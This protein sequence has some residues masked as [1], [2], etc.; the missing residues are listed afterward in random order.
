MNKHLLYLT[1]GLFLACNVE[2]PEPLLFEKVPEKISGMNFRNDVINSEEF[3][4]F[5][6]RNFYNGGGVAIGDIN[7]DGLSDIFFTSNMGGNKLYLNKGSWKFED[8][9]DQAGIALDSKWSTG[10]VMVDINGDEMLD[11]YVCNAG[12]RKGSNQKNALFINNG[13]LTF[14]EEA[15]KYGLDD[16]GYTTHAAFFDFDRDGD[17]D[18][19]LLNNSFIPVNTL[20]YSNKRDRRAK[21]WPVKDF[22]KGGGDKLL[23]NN[24]G[25]YVD[26]SEEVGI[27]GSLIGFGLGVTVGDVNNDT[28]PDIYVSND[29]FERDYLYINNQD[30]TF[31]EELEQRINHLSLSS[32]GADMADIDNDGYTEIFVTDMLPDDEYR[33]KTTT[34]FDNIDLHLLKVKQGFY[35]QFMH[36]TLQRNNG[37]GSFSEISNYS[38][39]AASDWSWGALMFDMNNDSYT[40]ILVCNGIYQDVIDQDFIDFFANEITQKMA[41]SGKKAALDSVVSKMPS[42]PIPNKAFKN[43]G[44]LKFEDMSDQWGFGQETFSNGAAYGDLDNDGDL[45]LVINNVN[46]TALVYRNNTTN[47]FIG[48]KLK[49]KNLNPFA[50]GAKV[51]I[52]Q[53]ENILNKELIPSRG[54]QSSV[55]YKLV[56]G[57]GENTQIDSIHILWPDG[58]LTRF[59]DFQLNQYQLV[60]FDAND[61]IQ[62]QEPKDDGAPLFTAVAHNF[63]SHVEDDYNDFYYERNIPVQ[64]SKESPVAAIGDINMDGIDDIYIGAAAGQ[65]SQLYLSTNNGFKKSQEAF[66]GQFKSFEDTCA[67][68]FDADNDGDL[69]LV[70][71]S[72]GNNAT[73]INRAFRDRLYIN[74]NGQFELVFGA[75]PAKSYNTATINPYDFDDDGDLDLF[76][77]SRSVPGDYG[78]SPGSFIYINNGK[79]QFQD[80]TPIVAPELALA[81][82][83]TDAIWA[84][85]LPREGVELI[86]TG[87]WMS[88]KIL[89]YDGR[90]FD[91][92]DTELLKYSGWWQSIE[93]SDLD[94]DGDQDLILGNLGENFYLEA[95]T[96]HPLLIW[97]NDFNGNGF[98]EKIITRR[99]DGKDMPV[100]MKR[101]L[102]DQL[103][104]LKKQNLM[105]SSYATKSIQELINPNILKSSTI[106]QINFLSSAI[107][108]NDGDGNFEMMALPGEVQLSCINDILTKDLNQDGYTDLIFAGNNHSFLPQF[109]RLDACRGKV[110]MNDGSANFK[111]LSA[112]QSGLNLNGAVRELKLLKGKE[113]EQLLVLINNQKPILFDLSSQN[114]LQ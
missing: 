14:K 23:E 100:V 45:D 89:S 81:G 66:F 68:F 49:F 110:L 93:A 34:A 15:K 65:A 60:T 3:N 113:K 37:D 61:I 99:I 30:G 17:L 28:Y 9:S 73:Y 111:L 104:G 101:D 42:N 55:D 8:I 71:G 2:E 20:N 98:F 80:A 38:N 112:T 40:D 48:I 83:V 21:D 84:D 31:S 106:K 63:E 50:V 41:I 59:E 56:F 108:I 77:G 51:T 18:V 72:G 11:I 13:D 62:Q 19:Y 96:L 90:K 24:N 91:V 79:G 95:D 39:V 16:A 5:N 64:L 75:L 86:L 88:P 22:L 10:V 92:I 33:L 105:H 44:N 94:N 87:E 54:F 4:I 70:V 76:I 82:M 26:I 57:L 53:N 109:S 69:D 47:N 74:K 6:Y 43:A 78:L 35:Y 67:E 103:P 107:A 32:M 58:N 27:Y 36:N 97:V 52:F 7:N 1:F 29:F 12:Y 25:I 85:V 114:F 102:T 46:Q